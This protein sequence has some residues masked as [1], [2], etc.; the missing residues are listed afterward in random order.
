[1]LDTDDGAAVRRAGNHINFRFW[2]NASSF[3]TGRGDIG[4]DLNARRGQ[5]GMWH[6]EVRYG[7]GVIIH[8]GLPIE[9]IMIE[10]RNVK[11]A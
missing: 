3:I 1:V 2:R 9:D 6:N 10:V 7:L 5:I 4:T 11:S 8:D